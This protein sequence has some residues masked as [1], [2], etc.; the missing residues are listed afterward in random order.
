M[1]K[2][3][4]LQYNASMASVLM[5]KVDCKAAVLVVARNE[6]E[7]TSRREK[8]ERLYLHM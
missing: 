6:L 3:T 2:I 8:L 4:T 5:E 7:A 1:L